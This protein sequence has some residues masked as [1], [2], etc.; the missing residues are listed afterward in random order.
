MREAADEKPIVPSF[1]RDEGPWEV[2]VDAGGS[3]GLCLYVV[4]SGA[5]EAI[6]AA[7][8]LRPSLAALRLTRLHRGVA[9]TDYRAP[10]PAPDPVSPPGVLGEEE[11]GAIAERARAATPGPWV[12]LPGSSLVVVGPDPYTGSAVAECEDPGDADLSVAEHVRL[13]RDVWHPNAAH[14]AGMCPAT[15]LRILTSHAALARL[16]TQRRD[17]A[18]DAR[19]V[20]KAAMDGESSLRIDLDAARADAAAWIAA[21]FAIA[22]DGPEQLGLRLARLV[23][24]A[25]HHMEDAERLRE[26]A[27]LDAIAR[28]RLEDRLD[29]LRGQ[30]AEA[31]KHLTETKRQLYFFGV[32]RPH[33]HNAALEIES[34]LAALAREPTPES[35]GPTPEEMAEALSQPDA[36][37][38]GSYA[39]PRD[40]IAA[41]I[42]AERARRSTSPVE[43]EPLEAGEDGYRCN[44]SRG[45]PPTW[46]SCERDAWSGFNVEPPRPCARRT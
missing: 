46:T 8:R 12:R 42:R 2:L 37:P 21:A 32:A 45:Q 30:M 22:C 28:Q 29:G 38:L 15:T 34:A 18:E 3:S 23:D 33:L 6:A 44:E 31:R 41:V 11:I 27:D 19:A 7:V 36:L 39:T 43:P 24:A 16:A 25:K 4:A 1:A 14:I 9:T 26:A 10:L 40:M 17:I 5:S 20:A 13:T 35:P